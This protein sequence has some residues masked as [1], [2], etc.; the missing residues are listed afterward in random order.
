MLKTRT[1]RDICTL[2]FIAALFTVAKSWKHL[3][4][5][6]KAE[7]IN[8]MCCIHTR[9]YYSLLQRKE[10]LTSPPTVD[11]PEN[12]MLNEISWSQKDKHCVGELL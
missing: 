9:V 6:L 12:M 3:K 4:C 7:W 11:E 2:K 1:Q 5:S 8:E 10:V